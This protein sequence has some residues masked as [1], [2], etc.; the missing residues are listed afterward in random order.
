MCS[1]E[2]SLVHK[3]FISDALVFEPA[4]LGTL[5]LLSAALMI[6]LKTLSDSNS[7]E[8]WLKSTTMA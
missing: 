4:L 5:W 1:V 2:Q 3:A 7:I 6:D 8:R